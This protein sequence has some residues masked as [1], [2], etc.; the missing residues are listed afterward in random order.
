MNNVSLIQAARKL[1]REYGVK[2]DLL[3]QAMPYLNS[4][5]DKTFVL[6]VGGSILDSM[7]VDNQRLVE[8]IN[9][10]VFLKAVGI[11]IIIVHGGGKVL[12][13]AMNKAGITPTKING[14]RVTTEP[15][16]QLAKQVF[17]GISTAIQ[18]HITVAGYRCQIFDADSKLVQ[19]SQ[20]SVDLQAVGKPR[21]V[22]VSLFNPED[23]DLIPVIPAITASYDGR[24][25]LYNVNADDV[26]SAVASAVNA[27]KLIL[28]TD[29]EGVLDEQ[30]DLI[31]TLNEQ[32]VAN[33][34]Q[35][36]II[37]SGMLPKVQSCLK[38]LDNGV[39]N[40]HIIKGDHR[41]F[42]DEILTDQGV[43]TLFCK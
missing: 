16:A 27:E 4:F 22:D 8:L 13:A 41:S 30:G 39:H 33:L 43:G 17:H 35:Q 15:V 12:D 32:Q 20:L 40:A 7:L 42:M 38:A 24:Y 6:K 1:V 11:N 26:A 29:V 18:E 25:A 21:E 37:K 3:H 10:I 14:L 2:G 34:I 23:P 31:S 36:G 9:D 28:M 19:S 5:K